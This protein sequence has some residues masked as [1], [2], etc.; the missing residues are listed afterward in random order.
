MKN[1]SYLKVVFNFK[2]KVNVG[3][4]EGDYR[5]VIVTNEEK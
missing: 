4:P 1:A 5:Q 2:G 3:W